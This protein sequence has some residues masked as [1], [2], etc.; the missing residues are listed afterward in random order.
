MKQIGSLNPDE[1]PGVHIAVPPHAG[2][3]C[4]PCLLWVEV[5]SAWSLTLLFSSLSVLASLFNFFYNSEQLINHEVVLQ[6]GYLPVVDLV[7]T[8]F[9]YLRAVNNLTS[10]NV[11]DVRDLWSM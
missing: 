10:T 8:T 7:E 9:A 4:L 2:H 5:L 1:Q 6:R 11:L 3:M